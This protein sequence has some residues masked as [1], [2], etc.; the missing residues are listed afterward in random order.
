MEHQP[1]CVDSPP[2]SRQRLARL[3]YFEYRSRVMRRLEVAAEWR[4]LEWTGD[5]ACTYKDGASGGE[6][7]SRCPV[8]GECLAAALAT[9]DIAGWRGGLSRSDRECLWAGMER[10]Y[11]DVCDLELMRVDTN[12]VT[13]HTHADRTR[14]DY[15]N[16]DWS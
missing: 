15:G 7:C 11:R 1:S 5:A 9:D 3:V 6:A 8:T 13:N 10:T 4:G 14:H 16:G 12:R 2:P